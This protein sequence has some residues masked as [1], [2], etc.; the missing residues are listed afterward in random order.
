MWNRKWMADFV[1]INL[2][3]FVIDRQEK[4]KKLQTIAGVHAIINAIQIQV[5][6]P[7]YTK[8]TR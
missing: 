2:H 4:T 5:Q 7:E 3:D 1:Q 8:C 6:I